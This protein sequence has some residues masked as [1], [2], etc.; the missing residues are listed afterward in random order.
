MEAAAGVAA[1]RGGSLPMPSSRK[2]WRAVSDHHPVRNV[3]DEVVNRLNVIHICKENAVMSE[4]FRF[5]KLGEFYI[6][7]L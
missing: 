3:A 2:E 7:E 1:P 6:L 5:W 4:E